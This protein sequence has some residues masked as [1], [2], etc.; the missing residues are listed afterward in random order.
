M[1]YSIRL[2]RYEL[3]LKRNFPKSL[4]TLH[5]EESGK[6][7]WTQKM[8]TRKKEIKILNLKRIALNALLNSDRTNL[9]C[10]IT[11]INGIAISIIQSPDLLGGTVLLGP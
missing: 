2:E 10:Q 7:L 9:P 6:L 8:A 3:D 5:S 4:N 11:H 1:C